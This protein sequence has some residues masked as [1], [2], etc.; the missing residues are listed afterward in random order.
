[1]PALGIFPRIGQRASL[2]RRLSMCVDAGT[3][4]D[5]VGWRG[6]GAKECVCVL[7]VRRAQ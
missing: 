1:M 2:P 4:S 5:S 3:F 6:L 7:P